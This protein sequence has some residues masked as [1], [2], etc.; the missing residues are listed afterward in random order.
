MFCF[1]YVFFIEVIYSKLNV[2]YQNSG[3]ILTTYN[4]RF[5]KYIF[6]MYF[7]CK[8]C[9]IPYY[10]H[11]KRSRS[12]VSWPEDGCMSSRNMSPRAKKSCVKQKFVVY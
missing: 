7:I 12:I 11:I 2:V 3:I 1:N 8:Q 9:G 6:Y 5:Y 10:V 4:Y